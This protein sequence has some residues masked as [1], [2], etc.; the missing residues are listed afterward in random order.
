MVYMSMTRAYTHA[1]HGHA[2]CH[3][4]GA[5][6][7]VAADHKLAEADTALNTTECAQPAPA[8]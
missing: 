4:R 7:I 1:I 3:A 2:M 6:A 5:A 8:P